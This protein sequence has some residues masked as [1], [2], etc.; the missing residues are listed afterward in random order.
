MKLYIV[1]LKGYHIYEKAFL[2]KKDAEKYIKKYNDDHYKY[3]QDCI[4]NYEPYSDIG[5]YEIIEEEV[6]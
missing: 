3:V 4:D 2:N 1:L 6:N 5:E